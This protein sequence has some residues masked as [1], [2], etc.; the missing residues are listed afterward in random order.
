MTDR[1]TPLEIAQEAY[2][3]IFKSEYGFKPRNI[4][5]EFWNDLEWL[6]REIEYM[7]AEIPE[8]EVVEELGFFEELLVNLQP[9]DYD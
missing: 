8:P 4:E 1:L 2:I 5:P 9:Q 3:N 7:C 6:S